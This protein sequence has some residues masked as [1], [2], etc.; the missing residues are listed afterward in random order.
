MTLQQVL[1]INPASRQVIA[2]FGRGNTKK[3][4]NRGAAESS[5]WREAE[6]DAS[7]DVIW[8]LLQRKLRLE[9]VQA[10]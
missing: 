2:L 10:L 3:F 9:R 5:F 6:T 1:Y 7:G 8:W 4:I